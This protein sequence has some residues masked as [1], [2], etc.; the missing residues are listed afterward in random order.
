MEQ[1]NINLSN[2][3]LW[4]IISSATTGIL[5]PHGSQTLAKQTNSSQ[6]NDSFEET[7]SAASIVNFSPTEGE[8]IIKKVSSQQYKPQICIESG[9]YVTIVYK[10]CPST[11]ETPSYSLKSD[12]PFCSS[13]NSLSSSNVCQKVS[14]KNNDDYGIANTSNQNELNDTED[15]TSFSSNEFYTT[16][17]ENNLDVTH[18][19][20]S[21][22]CIEMAQLS[23]TSTSAVCGCIDTSHSR[24]NCPNS[25]KYDTALEDGPS[26]PLNFKEFVKKLHPNNSSFVNSGEQK[27][28]SKEQFEA[29]GNRRNKR[30]LDHSLRID[31]S[32]LNDSFPETIFPPRKKRCVLTSTPARKTKNNL[33]LTG[34]T[35]NPFGTS[36]SYQNYNAFANEE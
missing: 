9:D 13:N 36:E 11:M 21:E 26:S 18:P 6:L 10:K 5:K 3:D 17:M 35:K 27:N 4:K 25:R 15:F 20:I 8:S 29:S 33:N 32:S 24:S 23:D 22:R 2:I 34:I 31:R 7:P 30:V 19:S 1:T 12:S 16:A 28:K 14:E